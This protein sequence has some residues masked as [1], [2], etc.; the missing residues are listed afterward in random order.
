MDFTQVIRGLNS[1][2]FEASVETDLQALQPDVEPYYISS[3]SMPTSKVKADEHRRDSRPYMMP[4]FDEPLSEI[5]V[6]FILETPVNAARSKIYTFLDTWRAFVRAGRGGMGNEKSVILNSNYRVDFKFPV[7]V[8]MLRG[9]ASPKI[10]VVSSL[11]TNDSYTDVS[12]LNTVVD[13]AQNDA[14]KQRQIENAI[15]SGEVSTPYQIVENN[16]DV[17]G[18]FQLEGMWLSSIR[19]PDL[20]YTKGGDISKIESVFYADS[21]RDLNQQ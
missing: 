6:T 13:R 1:Q 2:I 19:L 16:L 9:N 20:D 21:L 3:V 17:C 11:A 14:M 5:K 4:A 10:N 7:V 18:V 12:A 15:S 8:M